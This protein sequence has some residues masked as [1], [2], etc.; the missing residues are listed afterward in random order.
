MACS[1]TEYI[2]VFVHSAAQ[3]RQMSD[4]LWASTLQVF[5]NLSSPKYF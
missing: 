4:G 3:A 1:N 5:K 2:T